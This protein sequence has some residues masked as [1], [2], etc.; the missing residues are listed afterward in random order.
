MVWANVIVQDILFSS[1][2]ISMSM[3]PPQGLVRISRRVVQATTWCILQF[4]SH[5]MQRAASKNV[6]DS[7]QRLQY[8][9]GT[10]LSHIDIYLMFSKGNHIPRSYS[11]QEM[12]GLD[13]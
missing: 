10:I 7:D 8:A 9:H 6:C 12:V 3:P 11:D 1:S 13:L 5:S 2:K 4:L